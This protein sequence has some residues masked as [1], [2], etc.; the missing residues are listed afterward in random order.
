MSDNTVNFTSIVEQA[1]REALKPPP[2]TPS[3]PAISGEVE[4]NTPEP[5]VE[6]IASLKEARELAR[7]VFLTPNPTQVEVTTAE[8]VTSE[9]NMQRTISRERSQD[10]IVTHTSATSEENLSL[11]DTQLQGGDSQD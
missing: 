8:E 10:P 1:A 9:L 5:D 4:P 11:D 7:A 6:A 3:R 2:N